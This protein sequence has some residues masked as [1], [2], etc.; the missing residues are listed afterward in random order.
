MNFANAE[1]DTRLS[2]LGAIA[3]KDIRD[4][5]TGGNL[6]NLAFSDLATSTV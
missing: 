2:E 1:R 5:M 3:I 6:E 4:E